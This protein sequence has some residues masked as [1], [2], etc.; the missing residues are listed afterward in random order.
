MYDTLWTYIDQFVRFDEEE[1]K[2][3]EG[4]MKPRKVKKNEIL[5][6][7]GEICGETYF[8]LSGLIRFYYLTDQG[9]EITGFIFDEGLFATSHE[10]F[11]TQ[12]PSFQVLE[13]LEDGEVLCLGYKDLE[14]LYSLV[15]KC[16]E[17]VRKISQQRMSNAQRV[18]ASLIM[19]KPE[20][21]YTSFLESRPDLVG[22]IPQ[23]VLATYL[24]ITPVSLSR[25]R[26]RIGKGK[27]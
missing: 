7:L 24:G 5:V 20:E 19:H 18:M 22:R 27:N 15:P 11:F 1:K 3:F 9:L 26:H 13:S 25:I 10:S 4:R 14:E 12:M 17:L 23:K 6:D 8:I 16:Q 21:R 2:I